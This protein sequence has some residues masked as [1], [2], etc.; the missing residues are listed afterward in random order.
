MFTAQNLLASKTTQTKTLDFA[1]L[2]ISDILNAKGEIDFETRLKLE[3]A[4]RDINDKEILDAWNA[5][6][7]SKD[8]N[9]A[10]ELVKQLLHLLIN[11]SRGV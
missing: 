8:E 1:K 6:T 10:Q 11:K 2:F 4:V 7:G 5:F 9:E 3:N